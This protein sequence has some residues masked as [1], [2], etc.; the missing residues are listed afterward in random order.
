MTTVEQGAIVE[1]RAALFAADWHRGQKHGDRPYTAHLLEAREVFHDFGIGSGNPGAALCVAVLLHDVLEDTDCTLQLV[2]THFGGRV[3]ELVWAVS[4]MPK[5]APR[6]VR[7]AD[8]Y[9]KIR[10]C[11]AA[12]LVKIAD[13]IANVE[14][15]VKQGRDDLFAMYRK[16]QP[17]FEE[18]LSDTNVAALYPEMVKRLR[19]AFEKGCEA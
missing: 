13:R 9:A 6:K 8:A 10:A 17:A 19:M 1:V 18:L 12:A 14:S 4:G 2:T 11:P 16:E 7:V 15:C 3:A 5:G